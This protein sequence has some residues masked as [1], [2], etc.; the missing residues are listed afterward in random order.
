MKT[1]SR[2]LVPAALADRHEALVQVGGVQQ[3]PGLPGPVQD[4]QHD[5][6]PQGPVQTDDLLDVAEQ[7]GGIHLGQEAALLQVQ[8]HAEE[9][10]QGGK[11]GEGGR[12][13]G[14]KPPRGAPTS[15]IYYLFM[16]LLW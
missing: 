15:L 8:Q 11:D 12:E 1:G 4:R 2:A 13:G 9:E 7:P 3:G 10:L 6:V 5:L 16:L 14:L